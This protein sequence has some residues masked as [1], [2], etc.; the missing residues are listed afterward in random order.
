[1]EYIAVAIAI[2]AFSSPTQVNSL[3]L[4]D[5][6]AGIGQVWMSTYGKPITYE[7]ATRA[8][9]ARAL[10]IRVWLGIS[11]DGVDG[12]RGLFRSDGQSCGCGC[13]CG[14]NWRI[15]LQVREGE[16]NESGKQ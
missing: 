8:V 10:A 13:G 12:P 16:R 4:T 2:L 7:T 5:R 6:A 14:G 3:S 1:M 11:V 9:I 15:D